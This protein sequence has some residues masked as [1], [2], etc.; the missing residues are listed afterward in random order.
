M[1]ALVQRALDASV[2]IDNAVVGE[3]QGRGLVVFVGITHE[4][5][6]DTARR[7]AA[8]IV[9]LRIFPAEDQSGEFS[10]AEL[11]LPLLLISQFTLYAD[12]GKGRRPSWNA[13]APGDVAAPLFDACVAELR[14]FGANVS[15]GVFGADMQVR[16]T[17]DGPFTILL[18]LDP[19][20]PK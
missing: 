11:D 6:A 20:L 3:F 18:E 4:D 17:N 10:A 15:T 2:R 1:R 5:D 13:A 19:Q 8:K 7:L 12:T 16:L 9:H 14:G